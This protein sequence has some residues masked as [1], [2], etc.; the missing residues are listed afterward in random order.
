MT[1]L[2]RI[3]E[4]VNRLGSPNVPSTPR[5]LLTLAEFFQGNDVPGSIGCNLMP[6]PTPAEFHAVLSSIADRPDVADVRVQVTMFD[7]PDE[8]PFSDTVWVFTN[9]AAAA[10]ASW[11]PET[12][13]P[14]EMAEGWIA[15]VTYEEFAVPAGTRPVCCFW[16]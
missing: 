1:P 6:T 9:A 12:L 11:F 14:D 16:D 3:T 15:G 4:R 10:V 2:E 8:W 5:P 13:A 7:N